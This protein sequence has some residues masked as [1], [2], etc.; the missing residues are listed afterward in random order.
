MDWQLGSSLLGN[1]LV[2]LALLWRWWNG[3]ASS[4]TIR[5]TEYSPYPR[6]E[7]E[8]GLEPQVRNRYYLELELS[9]SSRKHSLESYDI[10]FDFGS[11]ANIETSEAIS[12]SSL[13]P[14]ESLQKTPASRKYR[15]YNFEPGNIVTFKFRISNVAASRCNVDGYAPGVK[16]RIVQMN[17]G[18]TLF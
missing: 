12:K 3:R 11:N 16:L 17:N 7:S 5:E 10:L 18:M 1:L 6:F 14:V 9:N 13:R 2:L 15:V 4:V 8:A